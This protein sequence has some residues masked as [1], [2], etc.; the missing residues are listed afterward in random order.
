MSGIIYY[1][2]YGFTW[3]VSLIPFGILYRISDMLYLLMFHLIHYRKRTVFS[4][5]RKSFPEKSD[6]EILD[7]A[8]QF[9]RHFSDF[10]LESIKGMSITVSSLDKRY[11]FVNLELIRELEIQNRNIALVSGHYN[12]WEW[13][14]G[15][16]KKIGHEFLVIYRPLKNKA[17]DRITKSIRSRHGVRVIPMEHIYREALQHKNNNTLFMVWFLADQRPP[18]S[19]KFWTRFLNREVSFYQ[20]V[21]KLANRLDLAVVFMDIQKIKRGHYE[22]MFKKLFDHGTGSR[23]NEITLRCV[24]EIEKEIYRQ[25]EFWLWSHKRFKHV[26]PAD[27]KLI[28][29]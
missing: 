14:F 18:R 3:I 22:I 6:Q 23:E 27:I 11:C 7:L 5:L 20:G 8:K 19:N 1:I 21:E 12:N 28:T 15:F 26:R 9:Y 4:N 25:P 13:M 29:E 16:P 10:L 17:V 24:N 2:L